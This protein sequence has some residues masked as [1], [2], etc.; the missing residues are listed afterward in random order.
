MFFYTN[1]LRKI[2]WFGVIYGKSLL[3]HGPLNLLN[4]RRGNRVVHVLRPCFL[5]T[6]RVGISSLRTSVDSGHGRGNPSS[7]S[8]AYRVAKFVRLGV[9][10]HNFGHSDLYLI[11]CFS[12]LWSWNRDRMPLSSAFVFPA[13]EKKVALS[14]KV[15]KPPKWNLNF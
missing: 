13:P 14:P 11:G 4:K 7:G 10:V 8:F 5:L 2:I 3:F 9:F 6:F 12:S 15:Q 1:T